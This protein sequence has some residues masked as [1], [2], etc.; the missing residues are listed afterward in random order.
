MKYTIRSCKNLEELA[1]CV[2]LQKE[3][4]GYADR[5][6]YPLRLLVNLMKMGGNAFGAFTP[7][8]QMV[9][10]VASLPAWRGRRRYYHSLSLGVLPAYENKGLGRALKLAQRRAALRAGIGCIEWTFDPL[11]A[12]NAFFNIE[13]LGA[14]ACCY[15]P[16]F[17][18]PVESRLQ[19]GLPTDRLIA[20]W[21]LN[22]SR[23]RRALSGKPARILRRKPA[24]EVSIPSNMHALVEAKPEEGRARQLAAREQLQRLIARKLVI[25]GFEVG[26]PESRYLL[27][28]HED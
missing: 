5:E 1:T 3:I 9:G 16:D 10:F 19:Q 8:S 20:E 13:R 6:I 11:R 26:T 4:W 2:S 17:Y 23:V 27:D 15:L 22:S 14:I 18:G 24:A 28:R 21:W 25:T 7:E 12:K